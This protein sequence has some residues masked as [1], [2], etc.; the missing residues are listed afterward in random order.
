MNNIKIL[1][2][3]LIFAEVA[4]RQSFTLAAKHLGMSKSAISQQLKRLEQ[5]IGQ[6]LLSRHTRGMSLTAAGEKLLS[7]C[8]L[9]RDQVDL[10]FEELNNS[11]E[12]P[13]GTF[14]LTIP[15]AFEKGIVI[16]ALRQL[17]IEFPQIEPEILVTDETKDLIKNNLDVAIYGGSLKDSNYRALPIGT[18]SEYFFATPAYTQKYGQLRKIDDLLKHQIIATSW[19][20]GFLD[21]YKNNE[22]SEYITVSCNFFAKTNTLP[23]ALEMVLHDM[24]IALL[25]EFIVQPKFANENLVRILPEYQGRQWPFYMVHRFHGEKPLHITRFYQLVKHFFSKANTKI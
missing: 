4:N 9:L 16:P 15:H 24:G 7:R 12:M 20:K 19:Q 22:L 1:P 21:I 10:A 5:G 14:A 6:Q 18:V 13:S 2:S 25:P 8:E 11:K 17:C 3:L 23:S